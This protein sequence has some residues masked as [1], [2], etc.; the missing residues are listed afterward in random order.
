MTNE[1]SS[2]SSICESEIAVTTMASPAEYPQFQRAESNFPANR[3]E[4]GKFDRKFESSAF[5]FCFV[6]LVCFV[7]D[8]FFFHGMLRLSRAFI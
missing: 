8:P 3:A 2:E 5:S 1:E 7:G 4:T 6:P